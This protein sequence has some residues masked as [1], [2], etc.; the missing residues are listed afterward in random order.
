MW[1]LLHVLGAGVW[2]GC[3][4]TEVAFE[5]TLSGQGPEMDKRLA[6]LHWRVDAW[7]EGPALVLVGLT[8][9]GLWPAARSDVALLTMAAAGGVAIVANLRCMHLVWLRDRAAQASDPE[10]FA[11]LDRQQ[12]QWGALVLLGLLVAA[13]AG[14]VHRLA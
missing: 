3:V 4:F 12:H 7:I 1:V 6:R 5:R 8:S 10:R 2:L 11:H 13:G 9:G 14:G